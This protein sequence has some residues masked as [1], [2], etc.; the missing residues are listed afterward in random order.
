MK[1]IVMV[2]GGVETLEY[3]SYQMGKT[4]EE[5]GFLVFYYDL[6]K[7]CGLVKESDGNE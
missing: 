4:F 3:F 1:R 6:K 5:N 7:L 2:I